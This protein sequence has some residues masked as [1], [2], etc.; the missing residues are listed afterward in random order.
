ML[1]SGKSRETQ[2][3]VYHSLFGQKLVVEKLEDLNRQSPFPDSPDHFHSPNR[4]GITALPTELLLWIFK[5]L[6]SSA[7]RTTFAFRHYLHHQNLSECDCEE[8]GIE[9]S[10]NIIFPYAQA[11]VCHQWRAVLAMQPEFWTRIIVSRVPG[12]HTPPSALAEYL[13][14]SRDLPLEVWVGN[15]GYEQQYTRERALITQYTMALSPHFHRCTII[16]YNV[17]YASSLPCLIKDLKAMTRKS[18]CLESLQL[19]S[20]ET[21]DPLDDIVR[22][23]SEY[24]KYLSLIASND[25]LSDGVRAPMS[26]L[27]LNGRNFLLAL[28]YMPTSLL[29]ESLEIQNYRADLR[30]HPEVE[31]RGSFEL[32][33]TGILQN[34]TMLTQQAVVTFTNVQFTPSS[35][36]SAG[37][38]L[39]DGREL[40]F[41]N[42]DSH[43]VMEAA[44]VRP[45]RMVIDNCD[46]SK[47]RNNV[48]LH[49]QTVELSNLTE[50][51]LIHF[52]NRWIGTTLVVRN[53][54]G[55]T[56]KVLEEMVAIWS[57][58]QHRS[59]WYQLHVHNCHAFSA[60]VFVNMVKERKIRL[61]ESTQHTFIIMVIGAR[62][63]LSNAHWKLLEMVDVTRQQIEWRCLIPGRGS[64]NDDD[65][66]SEEDASMDDGTSSDGADNSESETHSELDS[67][68][69]ASQVIQAPVNETSV[70]DHNLL[71]DVQN[72]Y[73]VQSDAMQPTNLVLPPSS[74]GH[75]E[76]EMEG[77]V[78]E[79]ADDLLD[80]WVNI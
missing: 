28:Q 50:A 64:S 31:R 46:L 9:E 5:L 26:K 13:L 69:I 53:C 41:S 6:S 27:V 54:P 24:Y 45:R 16:N 22:M 72:F 40:R 30:R 62:R 75:D 17:R 21:H 23:D 29:S 18:G 19:K 61:P 1:E 51:S 71:H 7:K 49:L 47:E 4:T 20:R 11:Q 34:L 59:E 56:D 68:Q 60:R 79:N 66:E 43:L 73:S 67:N 44:S 77:V 15:V 10:R 76:S 74:L 38:P 39:T 33:C 35:Q 78:E 37:V 32:S 25:F 63:P 70:E 80:Q 2:E 3:E 36:S 42:S 48:P 58:S 12:V 55:L 65:D 14:W 57:A 52:F 8:R